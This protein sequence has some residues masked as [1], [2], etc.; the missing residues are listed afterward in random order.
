[1]P[2]PPRDP[3]RLR[4]FARGAADEVRV[5]RGEALTRRGSGKNV[6]D[7]MTINMNMVRVV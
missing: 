2:D 7:Q 1:M 3:E 5:L 6:T 4:A